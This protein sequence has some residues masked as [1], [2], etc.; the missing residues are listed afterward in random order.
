MDKNW[1][2]FHERLQSSMKQEIGAMRE[3]LANM[4]QE[5]HCLLEGD[6]TGWNQIMIERSSLLERLYELRSR[7]FHV[8]EQLETWAKESALPFENLLH[9]ED[10]ASCETLSMREQLTALIEKMNEQNMRNLSLEAHGA[11]SSTH[12]RLLFS[13]PQLTVSLKK[14]KTTVATYPR[15]P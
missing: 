2:D 10:V 7:R 3:M 12:E 15:N 14:G 4:R 13:P 6:K 11:I 9:S 5:E 8:T 1:N